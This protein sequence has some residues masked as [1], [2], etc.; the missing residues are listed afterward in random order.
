MDVPARNPYETR[1][2]G[3][4]LP[5]VRRE[6]DEGMIFADPVTE[7]TGLSPMNDSVGTI[8]PRVDIVLKGTRLAVRPIRSLCPLDLL[9]ARSNHYA[10]PDPVL[11]LLNS[12][13][14]SESANILAC[15]DVSCNKS[16]SHHL[17]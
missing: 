2:D 9:F 17:L 7:M 4:V 5:F 12:C 15:T 8:S 10:R 1:K 11:H 3:A 13:I 16:L 14:L 6:E